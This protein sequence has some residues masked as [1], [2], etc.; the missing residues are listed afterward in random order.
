MAHWLRLE[1]R[2]LPAQVRVGARAAGFFR[3]RVTSGPTAPTLCQKQTI[4][5]LNPQRPALEAKHESR[6]LL[7]L[8]GAVVFGMERC[9]QQQNHALGWKLLD[10]SFLDRSFWIEGL[11][12]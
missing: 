8:A 7:F 11:R 10:E 5:I 2:S 6:A 1:Q 9:S 4:L 12:F 3:G